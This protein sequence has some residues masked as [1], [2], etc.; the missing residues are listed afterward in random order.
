MAC[1]LG[2]MEGQWNVAGIDS[3]VGLPKLSCTPGGQAIA[4][5]P[6]EWDDI[7]TALFG[8]K[9]TPLFTAVG[10]VLQCAMR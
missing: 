7:D 9:S 2:I 5:S 1:W 10:D 3:S 4:R 6:M 8:L